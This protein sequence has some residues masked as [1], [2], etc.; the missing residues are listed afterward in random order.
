MNW[1]TEEIRMVVKRLLQHDSSRFIIT[2]CGDS[3]GKSTLSK[4]IVYTLIHRFNK[5]VVYVD[6]NRRSPLIGDEKDVHFSK[7]G[8]TVKNP[9]LHFDTF[10]S[11]K[12]ELIINQLTTAQENAI[13]IIEMSPVNVFNKHN[14][15]PVSL[16]S[17][18]IPI[19]VIVDGYLTRRSHLLKAKAIFHENDVEFLGVVYNNFKI[20]NSLREK[21]S[22]DYWS[23]HSKGRLRDF[24]L[25]LI[26]TSKIGDILRNLVTS[27]K[28]GHNG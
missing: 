13:I 10:S 14:I 3:E 23:H 7:W 20:K 9:P 1:D 5:A 6:L 15:H 21:L 12:Q 27:I 18:G 2:S 16:A 8:A 24:L 11:Y 19:L 26:A 4:A 28:R 17:K 22:S 25:S